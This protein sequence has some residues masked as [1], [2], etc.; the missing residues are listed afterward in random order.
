MLYRHTN[1]RTART[2]ARNNTECPMTS[3]VTGVTAAAFVAL[4]FVR[5]KVRKV[6][7]LESPL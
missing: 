1:C 5:V 3:S 6:S 4:R 2:F 7:R